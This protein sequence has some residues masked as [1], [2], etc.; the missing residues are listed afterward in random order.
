MATVKAT[1]EQMVE[2]TP[3]QV[4][5]AVRD[6]VNVRPRIL[7]EHFGAYEVR[8][9]GQGAGTVVHWTLQA[10]KKRIR[11][12]LIEVSEPEAGRLVERDTKSSMVTTWTVGPADEGRSLVRVETTWQGAGGVPG[13]FE[14][15]FAPIGLRR[16]YGE[17]LTNLAHLV[18]RT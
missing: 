16:V 11:D 14:R 2:G 15:V 7:T 18:R 3:E 5:T 17:L 9:G 1:A 12:C 6:Y 13:F 10:T 4:G 8:A